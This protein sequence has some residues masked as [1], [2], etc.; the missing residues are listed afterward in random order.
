MTDGVG[1]VGRR[2]RPRGHVALVGVTASGKSALALGVARRRPR[3][4]L[5]AID[6][7]TVYRSMDIGTAKPTPGERVEGRYH[8]LDLVPPDEEFTVQRFQVAARDALDD[9][10]RRG[11]R[12]LLVGGTGLYHRAVVDG[13]DLP[14]RWPEIAARLRDAAEEPGA[15]A[16]LHAWLARLDPLAAG[17]IDPSNTRRT[18]RALEVTLGSGRPFSSFGPGLD[19]YPPCPVVLLGIRFDPA[20]VDAAI[21]RRFR[22]L[23]ERGFL[24]EVHRLAGRP[25]GLSRTARQALGYRELLA[26]VEDG[27]PLSQAVDDAIGRTRAFARRQWAWFRRDPRIR[28]LDPGGDPGAELLAAWDAASVDGATEASATVVSGVPA[29]PSDGRPRVAVRRVSTATHVTTMPD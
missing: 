28:W 19:C 17:R 1:P 10:E 3:C 9:I 24:E 2:V 18:L 8:L 26:H 13:L 7:M 14:G 21:E 12:A 6:S 29:H 11:A 23:L 22:C 20:A 5:V 25:G 15:P 27:I 16:R 4:E